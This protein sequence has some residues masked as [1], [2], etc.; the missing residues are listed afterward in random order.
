MGEIILCR[1]AIT[2]VNAENRFLSRTDAPLNDEGR[3]QSTLLGERLR[4]MRIDRCFVSPMKRCMETLS[5]ALPD[6]KPMLVRQE[7]REVDFGDWEL[8]TAEEIEERWPGMLAQRRGSPVQFRPPGG[9]SFADVAV[10]LTPLL[11]ELHEGNVLVVSHRGTLGALERLV[12]GLPL[13]Y[14]EIASM[15]P[16]GLHVV[17]ESDVPGR[18][19]PSGVSNTS[20]Q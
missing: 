4:S 2:A 15:E 16:A 19:S 3:R 20:L 10:R 7:L 17:S 13:D 12:R 11:N 6:C 5:L 8:L 14:R 9:E 18:T 1:H